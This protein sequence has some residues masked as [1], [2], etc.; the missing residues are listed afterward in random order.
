MACLLLSSAYSGNLKGFLTKPIM[1]P[2]IE[3]FK[4]VHDSGLPIYWHDHGSK[5]FV[6]SH[7]NPMVREVAKN[8]LQYVKSDREGIAKAV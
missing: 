8:S 7:I 6:K 5:D 4:Q 1:T 2:K 3:T